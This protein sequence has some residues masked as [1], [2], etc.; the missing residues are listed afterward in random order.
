MFGYDPSMDENVTGV[1]DL[2]SETEYS[3]D[4]T[5]RLLT[6]NTI[7]EELPEIIFQYADGIS[8]SDFYQKIAN[9]TPATTEHLKE[10]IGSLIDLK[11]IEVFSPDGKMRTKCSTIKAGD[12]LKVPRQTIIQFP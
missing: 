12:I 6:L 10:V 7:R 1:S 11:A 2:F 4:E 9:H 5:A 8:F 3:F